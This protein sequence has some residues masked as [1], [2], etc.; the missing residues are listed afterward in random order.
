[1]LGV[2]PVTIAALSRLVDSAEVSSEALAE[3]VEWL[4]DSGVHPLEVARR[5]HTNPGAL[6]RR[7]QRQDRYD[8]ARKI[9]P[10]A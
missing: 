10:E 1:M 9:D 4:L 6:A 5:H 2:R 3:N 8:L 7:L